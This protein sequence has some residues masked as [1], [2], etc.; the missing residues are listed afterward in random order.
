MLKMG[1][2]KIGKK[3]IQHSGIKVFNFIKIKSL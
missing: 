3:Y 1:E 2:N